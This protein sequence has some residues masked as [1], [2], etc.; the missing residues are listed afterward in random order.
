MSSP[1]VTPSVLYNDA[2]AGIDW[3]IQIGR[4]HV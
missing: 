4:A 3:L 2:F 1:T